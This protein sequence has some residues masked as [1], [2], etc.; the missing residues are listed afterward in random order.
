MIG[1]SED[2]ARADF[3]ERVLRKAFDRR[4][5]AH[6][7]EHRR[8]DDPVRRSQASAAR[9]TGIAAQNFEGKIHRSSVSGEDERETNADDDVSREHAERNRVRFCPLQFPGVGG[10]KPNRNQQGDPDR[11]DIDVLSESH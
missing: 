4:G 3:F 11:E 7:H 5:G 6:R 10:G 2:D 9:A 1:V 8:L